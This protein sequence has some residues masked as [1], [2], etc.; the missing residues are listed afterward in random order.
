LNIKRES[1]SSGS[2][3]RRK[4]KKIYKASEL[5]SGTFNI[6]E[7]KTS[8]NKTIKRQQQN[9]I[10]HRKKHETNRQTKQSKENNKITHLRG[11]KKEHCR[12]E[13]VASETQQRSSLLHRN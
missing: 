9:V 8:T 5:S 1:V 7:T 10:E 12:R 4:Q 2:K 6:N 11:S 13:C 3:H